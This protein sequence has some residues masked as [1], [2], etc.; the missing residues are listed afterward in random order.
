MEKKISGLTSAPSNYL[1]I[2]KILDSKSGK[3]T[4]KAKIKILTVAP[5][6]TVPGS[7][8]SGGVL[9]KFDKNEVDE[10]NRNVGNIFSTISNE[11]GEKPDK[12]TDVEIGGIERIIKW[13]KEN[14]DRVFDWSAWYAMPSGDNMWLN[15]TTILNAP[16]EYSGVLWGW[17]STENNVK[18]HYKADIDGTNFKGYK[19]YI[20][21]PISN[22]DTPT[23]DYY[24]EDLASLTVLGNTKIQYV[25]YTSPCAV[26]IFQNTQ[27]LTLRQRS[28]AGIAVN[29]PLA[30]IQSIQNQ[31]FLQ[32]LSV[33]INVTSKPCN[34]AEI[35]SDKIATE[36][37]RIESSKIATTSAED[38]SKAML[39]C[40]LLAALDV[41]LRSDFW[42]IN[43]SGNLEITT[44]HEG[45][46]LN[47]V[48]DYFFFKNKVPRSANDY[49]QAI[50][51]LLTYATEKVESFRDY[52]GLGNSSAL[53]N[54]VTQQFSYKIG[55]VI[56]Q[57]AFSYI[58]TGPFKKL[59]A[60]ERKS[61]IAELLKNTACTGSYYRNGTFPGCEDY[62][63]LTI[64]NTPDNQAT[65]LLKELHGFH[66]SKI[67]D[68]TGGLND[69]Q[70]KAII[71]KL[72]RLW[73]LSSDYDNPLYN[74]TADY[75]KFNRGFIFQ[76]GRIKLKAEIKNNKISFQPYQMKK[77]LNG[78]STST[79][80]T[81]E[82]VGG[83]IELS[84][85]DE[86]L[87]I[88][89]SDFSLGKDKNGNQST[90]SKGQQY[91][92]P[93]MLLFAI[94][95]KDVDKEFAEG[96]VLLVEAAMFVALSEIAISAVAVEGWVAAAPQL[97]D[98]GVYMG[99]LAINQKVKTDPGWTNVHK[100][101]VAAYCEVSFLW[102]GMRGFTETAKALE[103][104]LADHCGT[105]PA[106][107]S[108]EE[109]IL[110][111]L[112]GKGACFTANTPVYGPDL[113]TYKPIKDIKIGDYVASNNKVTSGYYASIAN[114]GDNNEIA[115][116]I[117]SEIN[118]DPYT[119]A[120]QKELDKMGDNFVDARIVTLSMPKADGSISEIKLLRPKAWLEVKGISEI[121]SNTYLHLAE[122]GLDGYATVVDIAHYRA[123][124]NNT[125]P[126]DEWAGG[127]VTGVFRHVTSS[128]FKL[129]FSNGDS[130]EVTGT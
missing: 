73:S 5:S 11:K 44:Y 35:G 87:F 68:K 126:D 58:L 38:K 34:S 89:K 108:I 15:C 84:P 20:V 128:I 101:L 116:S 51:F 3:V 28:L 107:G 119:S 26:D 22:V 69:W 48:S 94:S 80:D 41:E 56:A 78:N 8:G 37:Y 62:V 81:P 99:D 6:P 33:A 102:F 39:Y 123:T 55:D 66:T 18:L 53:E 1:I 24:S 19:K 79:F 129:Q 95:K 111:C 31:N 29:W 32:N 97:I 106:V 43:S 16:A 45:K 104:R 105:N 54:L 7:S 100:D 82:D 76:E 70:R 30:N 77:S 25:R 98:L 96:V 50:N 91:R 65:D 114:S 93:A 40:S 9:P 122:L 117:A 14:K 13:A 88:C 75:F 124:K 63:L 4:Y 60:S 67:I 90:F 27:N 121:G 36:L 112:S 17:V 120:G 115:Y 10:F 127:L 52:A 59:V 61:L 71:S 110:T 103:K 113:E 21:D 57:A 92:I 74:N 86:V 125:S 47:P 46:N 83:P 2:G 64:E 72:A 85:Y 109:E 12:A 130:I 49:Q 42:N 118:P 23:T